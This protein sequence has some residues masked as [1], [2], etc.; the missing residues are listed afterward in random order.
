MTTTRSMTEQVADTL[1]REILSL[2]IEPGSRIRQ[3]QLAARFNVSRLP[4]RQALQ[5]LAGEGLVTLEPYVGARVGE[6]SME[7]CIEFYRIR[8]HLEPLVVLDSVVHTGPENVERIR[9]LL[10]AIGS[11]DDDIESWMAADYAFHAAI[12][13]QSRLRV[14]HEMIEGLYQKT[15]PYRR[16]FMAQMSPE[17]TRTAQLEHT[18]ILSA[19]ER[20]DPDEAADLSRLHI[21]RTRRTLVNQFTITQTGAEI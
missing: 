15:Q 19:I 21:R 2:Q 13:A 11:V 3:D 20:G 1:R 6:I 18:M 12:N 7:S 9:A 10:E 5:V 4:I 8:E 17:R 16:L 14:A